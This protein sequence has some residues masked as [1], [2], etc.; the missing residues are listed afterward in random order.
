MTE[1]W[2]APEI[3]RR[4]KSLAGDERE[5][6][7]RMLDYHR[8]ALLAKCA[9]LTAGQ[10]KT[11][12]AGPSNLTLLGLVR[13]MAL[14]ERS[15]VRIRYAG[16]DLPDLYVTD[17]WQDAEFEDLEGADAEADFAVYR[18]ET[19]ACDAALAGRDL[20]ERWADSRAEFNV[21]WLY[22]HLI[23]EYAR[24]NGHADLIRER[25]DGRTGV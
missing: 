23:E 4:E 13:H 8:D 18:A 9:G 20:D 16:E 12:S 2:T 5:M 10:L 21:R 22:V 15:W 17:D 14:V 24:H 6:L 25:I 1:I 11:A 19:E 7:E 3:E